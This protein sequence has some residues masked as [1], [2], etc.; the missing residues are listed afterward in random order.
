MNNQKGKAVSK[1]FYISALSV[2]ASFAVVVLHVNGVFWN[3]SRERYWIT[4]N[5][6]ES[7]MYFAVPVFFMITGATLMNYNKSFSR[8]V[9]YAQ[10]F[11]LLFG[12]FLRVFL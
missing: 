7:V 9:S 1:K 4:A 8:N 11:R 6:I 2:L 12:Q 5:I 3:F 10:L